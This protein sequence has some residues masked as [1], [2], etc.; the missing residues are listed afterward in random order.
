MLGAVTPKYGINRE[1]FRGD[2]DPGNPSSIAWRATASHP[3]APR[4][5]AAAGPVRL[6]SGPGVMF[7][8]GTANPYNYSGLGYDGQPA[9][10]EAAT[11]IYEVARDAWIA[12]PPLDT[13][14]MEH[15]ALVH[16]PGAWWVVGGFARGQVVTAG[17]TR[18]AL[19][20]A[21]TETP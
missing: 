19:T 18:L 8:G 17:V 16:T 13:P 12:G 14:T 3:G 6:P 10:P 20:G 5:R 9:E 21:A 1:C 7:V 4:Y 15:R 11:W 2:I